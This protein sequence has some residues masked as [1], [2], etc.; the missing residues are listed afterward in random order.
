[1]KCKLFVMAAVSL[2]AVTGYSQPTDKEVQDVIFHED[3]LFWIAYNKC[4]VSAMESLLTEDV[5]FYHDMGGPSYG[6]DS[7]MATVKRNLC[8]NNNFRL[9]RDAVPG[10]VK[11]F[12][13]KKDGTPYGAIISGEHVF[14]INQAGQKEYLDG[15][16]SF[17]QL[18]MLKNS[19]W[20]MSRIL[21][22]DHHPAKQNAALQEKPVSTAVLNKLVGKYKG[23]EHLIE[24]VNSNGQ[25]KLV[26]ENKE[27]TLKSASDTEFFMTERDLKFSFSNNKLTVKEHDQV[28]EEAVKQ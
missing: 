7:L 9:R 2:C 6:R 25:L 20:R 27:Y 16:A 12:P 21:S 18:W 15:H 3:S 4:D 14:Y 26:I 13:L 23:P 19:K 5:E 10:T 17:A 8:S 28:V 22:Y 11:V 24:V 1:M